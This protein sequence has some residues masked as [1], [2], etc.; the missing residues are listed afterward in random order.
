M[1]ATWESIDLGIPS[2]KGRRKFASLPQQHFA[3]TNLS[4]RSARGVATRTCSDLQMSVAQICLAHCEQCVPQMAFYKLVLDQCLVPAGAGGTGSPH[5][6]FSKP[7][8]GRP[9]GTLTPNTA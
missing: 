8:F 7:A 9:A 6:R 3:Q 4:K 1:N 2:S 5:N